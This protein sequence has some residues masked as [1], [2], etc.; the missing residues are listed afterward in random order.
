[1]KVSTQTVLAVTVSMV[2]ATP[3]LAHTGHGDALGL[4]HGFMHPLSGLDHILAML[5]V[6]L[7]ATQL[8]GRAL[9]MLPAAF[10]SAMIAGGAMGYSGIVIPVV[11]QGI[12]LSVIVMGAL[13]ALGLKM[14][15]IAG[16]SLV[17][18]FAVFHGHAHGS[19]GAEVAFFSLYAAG[20]VTATFLVH[21]T[22]IALGLGLK[23]LEQNQ[24][25]LLRRAAGSAGA[26]AGIALLAG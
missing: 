7:Y 26:M 12:A 5:A 8:S 11:E 21:L 22:G 9:W 15:A 13:I 1:M 23:T 3:A 10:M 24:A 25:L 4:A 19:E 2:L 18:M 14:P 16:M 6:G 20:F 17:A